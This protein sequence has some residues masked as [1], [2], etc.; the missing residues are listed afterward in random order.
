MKKHDLFKVIV[1]FFCSLL[2]SLQSFSSMSASAVD[3]FPEITGA[4]HV[5]L[6]NFESDKIIYTKGS[7]SEKIAPAS[8]VKLMSGLVALEHLSERQDEYITLS[9]E[10]LQGVE[11]YTIN[12]NPGETLKI[13]DLLYGLICGGG[14]DAA[15][16][17]AELAGKHLFKV[18]AYDG[19]VYNGFNAAGDDVKLHMHT[20]KT[21]FRG[22]CSLF[23][24][25]EELR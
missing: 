24:A 14:N 20:R 25:F 5:Y 13:R 23:K 18:G 22:E 3:H 15:V 10:M 11:G 12:L 16:A 17:L 7:G 21:V 4:A 9:K 1:A 19:A 2:F 6:Y 8:T